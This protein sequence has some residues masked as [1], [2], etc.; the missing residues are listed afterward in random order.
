MAQN[1]RWEQRRASTRKAGSARAPDPG[2]S[3]ASADGDA[4]P[5]QR[6]HSAAP[7]R[8]RRRSRLAANTALALLIAYTMI[9]FLGVPLL[10]ERVGIRAVADR[11]NGDATIGAAIF[12]PFTFRLELA[13]LRISDEDGAEVMGFDQFVGNFDPIRTIF[14]G[15][16]RFHRATLMRPS[17]SIVI[18]ED[19]SLNLAELPI[20]TDEQE[21]REPLKRIPRIVIDHIGMSEASVAFTD[22]SQ[23]EPV[24]ADVQDLTFT[25]DGLDTQPERE[26]PLRLVAETSA[27]ERFAWEGSLFVDPL[28]TR[29]VLT[30]ENLDLPRFMPYGIRR[31]TARLVEGRMDLA[32]EYSFAPVRVPREADVLVTSIALRDLVVRQS[33]EPLVS[34]A[35]IRGANIAADAHARTLRIESL[36]IEG[37]A[38]SVVREQSGEFRFTRLLK[39]RDEPPGAA[40][41]TSTPDARTAGE[42]PASRRDVQSIEYPIEQLVTAI[43]QLLADALGG[44]T[45]SIERV[46]LN[47]AAVTFEDRSTSPLTRL[48]MNDLSIDAGP[49]QSEEDYRTPFSMS[50]SV[51]DKGRFN[52]QGAALP[53]EPFLE[54]AVEAE[55]IDVTVAAAY[56][57]AELGGDLPAARLAGGALALN[58]RATADMARPGR[59]AAEW[60]GDVTLGD[61]RL[62][63]DQQEQALAALTSLSLSGD[64]GV[65]MEGDSG[66]QLLWNG[67]VDLSGAQA[68]GPLA[69]PDVGPISLV[70]DRGTLTGRLGAQLTKRR[71]P[72]IFFSI[73]SNMEGT[74]LRVPER[75]S[76]DFRLARASVA[77]AEFDSDRE[78]LSIQSVSLAGP[79]IR[80]LVDL[81]PDAPAGGGEPAPQQQAA[82]ETAA[83]S[84]DATV[85]SAADQPPPALPLAVSIASFN[86]TGGRV[87][88]HDPKTDP[89]ST[90]LLEDLSIEATDLSTSGETGTT[91]TLTSRVQNSGSLRM[92]GSANAFSSPPNADVE[93][94][95]SSLPL[96]PYNAL[97]GWYVGYRIDRGRLNLTLPI[98]LDDT[99]LDG[100]LSADLDQFYLGDSVNSPA[101]PD[102]PVKLGLALL[103]DR[104]G[105]IKVSIPIS[106]DVTDPNFSLGGVIWSAFTNVIVGAATSPFRVLGSLFA[107]DADV[108]LS[109]IAFEPGADRLTSDGLSKLDALARAMNERPGISLIISG[110]YSMESDEPVV[111]EQAFRQRMLDRLQNRDPTIRE[112]TPP[113]YRRAVRAAYRLL[114]ERGEIED[115][116]QDTPTETESDEDDDIFALKEEAVRANLE[117]PR[118]E[119]EALARR[120]AES[121]RAVLVEDNN[122]DPERISITTP[123]DASGPEPQAV[124]DLGRAENR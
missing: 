103:R 49:I 61:L 96:N 79:D 22:L 60:T 74:R 70:A 1:K 95:V 76:L 65:A 30:I 21:Q 56:L 59:L 102:A 35:A 2:G 45:T 4:S 123:D 38:A 43:E 69:G 53:L 5:P 28:T 51:G 82:T 68:S 63:A 39:N 100:R 94:E 13:D 91:F 73:D 77:S 101:A 55:S 24:R 92:A 42:P 27:G 52:L 66:V 80:A 36:D 54:T 85:G 118:A 107:G 29:G 46:G 26:N 81:V 121:V 89:P 112:L 11:L 114:V 15:G 104:S 98:Q 8:R 62:D 83:D 14:Q 9:G 12:N 41:S 57:P 33:D 44:W 10:L 19:G 90:A 7:E 23:P 20:Q 47:D 119:L 108:D 122:V 25:L 113:V 32:L 124:F 64:A 37:A 50:A 93:I 87:E 71:S 116:A 120:R 17:A 48:V 106:G 40:P 34:A 84:S 75:Q 117:T 16:Y 6:D 67:S 78:S 58:G 18:A 105:N 72:Q 88:L 110:R 97:A 109:Q 31:T 99:S 115:V 111:R 3:Q 86:L